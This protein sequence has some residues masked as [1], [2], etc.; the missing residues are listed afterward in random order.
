MKTGITNEVKTG[1]LVVICLVAFAGL[2]MKVTNF[3]F[4]QKGYTLKSR[5]HFTGGVKKHA[6]VCLSGVE[7]GEVRDI[8]LVYG[9]ET[10]VELTL[11]IQDGVKI[12]KDSKAL[13]TTLGL[14]GE[15]YVEIQSGLSSAEYAKEGDEITGQDPFR[16][17][18]LIDVGK[19]VAGDI[20]VM[21]KEITATAK[22]FGKLARNL[23]GTIGTNRDKI[24]NIFDNFE[25][26]SDNFREFSDDI[27]FHPWKVLMKGREV[28]KEER[29]KE[30]AARLAR[31]AKALGSSVD[32]TAS[33]DSVQAA[34]NEA[35]AASPEHKQN[36]GSKK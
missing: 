31:K 22:D 1:L 16:M 6:P 11:W 28:P 26:T 25:E 33:A 4:G 7:V 14:M 23:D 2:A 3:S 32:T 24:D 13:S 18:E 15:K 30:R 35:V 21:S 29:M 36:F 27:R 17:E 12:R 10:I 19:K 20:S 34:A 9:D 8:R 5:F